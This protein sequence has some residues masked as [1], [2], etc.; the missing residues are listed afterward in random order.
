MLA[1]RLAMLSSRLPAAC[2]ELEARDDDAIATS[3]SPVGDCSPAGADCSENVVFAA[4]ERI[5]N[6]VTD[7]SYDPLPDE[8][9]Y[10][11]REFFAPVHTRSTDEE[12]DLLA[13]PQTS[14]PLPLSRRQ[15]RARQ[16]LLERKMKNSR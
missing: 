12:N 10:E 8:A 13:F 16:K 14:K 4:N 3:P 6:Q 15:R 9:E 5:A 7:D 2:L 11:R 1:A